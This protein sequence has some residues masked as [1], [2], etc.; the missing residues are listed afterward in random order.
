MARPKKPVPATDFS[1]IARSIVCF[2]H[3]GWKNFKIATLTIEK[4]VVV[5]EHLSDPYMQLEAIQKLDLFNDYAM[6]RLNTS[7]QNGKAWFLKKDKDGNEIQD[8]VSG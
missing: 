1:G 3:N 8:V 2:D 4:G 6:M 7:W 5:K